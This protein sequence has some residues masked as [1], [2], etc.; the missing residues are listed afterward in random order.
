[1]HQI[2]LKEAGNK[3]AELIRLV[4]IGEEVIITKDDGSTYKIVPF[5]KKKLYPKFG[6]AKGMVEMS[7]DFDDPIEGFE[8]YMP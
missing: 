4:G 1:M 7:D 6:S 8:D 5:L 2:E 3:L